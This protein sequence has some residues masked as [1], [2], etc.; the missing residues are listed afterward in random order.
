MGHGPTSPIAETS[1]IGLA[2][3]TAPR[4]WHVQSLVFGTTLS[5]Q[6]LANGYVDVTEPSTL[7]THV[8][9]YTGTSENSFTVPNST[10]SATIKVTL[11]FSTASADVGASVQIGYL[12]TLA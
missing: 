3:S 7:I 10:S 8:N 11:Q 1:A 9:Q 2:N 6:I 4:V 5:T 12:E